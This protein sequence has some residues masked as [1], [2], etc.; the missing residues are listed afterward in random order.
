[1]DR[2]LTVTPR[3]SKKKASQNDSDDDLLA[4]SGVAS[5]AKPHKVIS[6]APFL[7]VSLT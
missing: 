1:M 6:S 7:A 3:M 4:Y 5:S 2:Y